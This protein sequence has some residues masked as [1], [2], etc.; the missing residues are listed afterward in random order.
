MSRKKMHPTLP[1]VACAGQA[2]VCVP[3]YKQ[4]ELRFALIIYNLFFVVFELKR[5]KIFK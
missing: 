2:R 4:P 1:T 5:Q 3:V